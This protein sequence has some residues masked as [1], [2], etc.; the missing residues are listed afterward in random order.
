MNRISGW[1]KAMVVGSL[2][3][4]MSGCGAKE[5]FNCRE[6]CNKKKECGS[7]SN[8]NVQNCVDTCSDSANASDDYARKVNTC[9]ECVEPLSCTD[10]KMLGCYSN[11][12]TLP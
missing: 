1:V 12:P 5:Y 7:D 11:C 8:Y 10:Y 2:L 6:L 9:K 3:T 4:G